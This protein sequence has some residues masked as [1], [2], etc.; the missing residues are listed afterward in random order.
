MSGDDMSRL[1]RIAQAELKTTL[2]VQYD[3]TY[4]FPDVDVRLVLKGV[5]LSFWTSGRSKK[6]ARHRA[7]QDL[8][9]ELEDRQITLHD[10]YND[11]VTRVGNEDDH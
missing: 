8:L 9:R 6:E 11:E 1:Q 10:L 7:A 4:S 5:P 3:M 2:E